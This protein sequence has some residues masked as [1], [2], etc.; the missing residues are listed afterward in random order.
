[1]CWEARPG[2]ALH[3]P[4]RP[5][6][7]VRPAWSS[8]GL[9]AGSGQPINR[10]SPW[11]FIAESGAYDRMPLARAPL[12]KHVSE[13]DDPIERM[14]QEHQQKQAN[15]HDRQRRRGE[16]A[17]RIVDVWPRSMQEQLTDINK[18]IAAFGIRVAGLKGDFGSEGGVPALTLHCQYLHYALPHAIALPSLKIALTSNSEIR[19]SISGAGA[20]CSAFLPRLLPSDPD[21]PQREIRAALADYV[22]VCLNEA[23]GWPP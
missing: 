20:H 23:Q 7:S 12:G 2:G 8:A 5:F 17:R 1:M 9:A 10:C 21:F 18:K 6:P 15:E 16:L 13:T 19:A 3:R 11:M 22:S 4:A 14:L